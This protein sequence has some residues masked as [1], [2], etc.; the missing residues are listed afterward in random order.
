[1]ERQQ[2]L[3]HPFFNQL[4]QLKNSIN[5]IPTDNNNQI[6]E[7]KIFCLNCIDYIKNR[8][9]QSSDLSLI[10]SNTLSLLN[11]QNIQ[12]C[13]NSIS[14]YNQN[15]N[16]SLL[17]Q[18]KENLKNLLSDINHRLPIDIKLFS[19]STQ[20]QDEIK[21]LI[22]VYTDEVNKAISDIKQK[23]NQIQNISIALQTIQNN[24]DTLN[25]N[26]QQTITQFNTDYSN[27]KT[28]INNEFITE[29]SKYTAEASK[30]IDEL[31]NKLEEA[32][33]LVHA[34]GNTG[35]SH[36]Y[37]EAAEYHRRQANQFRWISL[38]IMMFF[39]LYLCAT[40]YLIN[41]QSFDWKISLIRIFSAALFIYPAQYAANQSNKHRELENYNRK[42][43]LDLAAINPFIELLDEAKKKEIK[44][45]LTERYFKPIEIDKGEEDIPIPL[46]EKIASIFNEV[47][48]T[49]KK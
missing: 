15:K 20:L 45:K 12:Q 38:G 48:K 34:I 31:K 30:L 8:I 36:S 18:L 29:K 33:K 25:K 2:L 28:N 46:L 5:A 13:F 42:M 7:I 22:K 6:A 26:I 4:E 17:S 19:G 41:I 37:K 9:I 23:E 14:Q 47:I 39:V 32:R 1:M 11:N 21:N 35:V 27:F 49:I 3:Q 16:L 40:I 24:Y 10:D 44:E 43:E